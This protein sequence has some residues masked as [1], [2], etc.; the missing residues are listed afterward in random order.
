MQNERT[1]LLLLQ[2]KR[3]ILAFFKYCYVLVLML[4]K[5]ITK[6][7]ILYTKLACKRGHID[8]VQLL[9]EKGADI[10]QC[11]GDG[12]NPLCIAC[13]EG[14]Y[15]IVELLLKKG[16]YF[17]QYATQV[18]NPLH[19]AR[20]EKHT[21]IEKLLETFPERNTKHTEKEFLSDESFKEMGDSEEQSV[22]KSKHR[23]EDDFIS[24]HPKS[25]NGEVTITE[26]KEYENPKYGT[27]EKEHITSHDHNDASWLEPIISRLSFQC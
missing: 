27:V 12:Y 6:E 20:Q 14:Y 25:T 19:L 8:T 7:E 10:N 9:L 2:V 1:I 15:D 24:L 16:A 26:W 22:V 17:D 21:D 18:P 4:I 13:L 23:T 5:R 3:D 11:G